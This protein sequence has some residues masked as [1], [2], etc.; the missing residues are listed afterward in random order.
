MAAF[1]YADGTTVQVGDRVQLQDGRWRAVVEE[2]VVDPEGSGWP[3]CGV[4]VRYA[5][6]GLVFYPDPIEADVELIARRSP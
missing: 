6:V 3:G 1:H 2:S 5:E 4:L